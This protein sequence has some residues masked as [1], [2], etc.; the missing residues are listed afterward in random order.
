MNTNVDYQSRK[1]IVKYAI[2]ALTALIVLCAVILVV[3][4]IY[5]AVSGGGD[6]GLPEAKLKDDVATKENSLYGSLI[7]INNSHEYTFPEN[8]NSEL[9]KISTFMSYQDTANY[10]YVDNSFQ[11]NKEAM[12]HIHE[13]LN[14]MYK[15]L[16]NEFIIS[17]AYRTYQ[18]QEQL[19]TSSAKAGFSDHHSG[20]TFSLKRGNAA[21]LADEDIEWIQKNAYKYGIIMRYP[22]EKKEI[23]EVSDYKNCFRYVGVPHATY[24][25]QHKDE[26]GNADYLCLEEYIEFLKTNANM[27]NKQGPLKVKCDSDIYHIYY[28]EFSGTQIDI[29]VPED[30]K[31][32]PYEIS[33][34]NDGGV[35]VT[36]KSK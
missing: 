8:E 2:I 16:D 9:I 23:T 35:I 28:Y 14:Q 32:Y 11:L 6:S 12:P 34:T 4:N 17:S 5:N 30:E 24:I 25:S 18:Y 20:Y 26:S 29:K 21:P 1:T 13:M 27:T 22:E 10:A 33:G 31:T 36:I 7:L 3:W 15:D 19:T